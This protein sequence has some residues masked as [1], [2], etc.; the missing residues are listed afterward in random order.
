M[1]GGGATGYFKAFAE[2]AKSTNNSL[3]ASINHNNNHGGSI[4]AN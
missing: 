2:K 3:V 4:E 1:V